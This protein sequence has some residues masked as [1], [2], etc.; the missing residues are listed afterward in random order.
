VEVNFAFPRCL[1]EARPG[2]VMLPY[3]ES[4]WL[5]LGPFMRRVGETLSQ[6]HPVD[7][8]AEVL[9]AVVALKAAIV[10]DIRERLIPFVQVH[11]T[12]CA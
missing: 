2:S 11:T 8:H 1:Y 10:A 4:L 3:V 9:A 6:T 12:C 7:R 5:R